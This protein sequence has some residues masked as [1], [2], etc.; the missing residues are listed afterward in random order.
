MDYDCGRDY[1]Y[2]QALAKLKKKKKIDKDD[3]IGHL[4]IIHTWASFARERDMNFFNKKHMRSIEK[5]TEDALKLL[6]KDG[7]VDD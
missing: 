4:Q 5:W 2:D 7:E 3:V 1:E 6:Q